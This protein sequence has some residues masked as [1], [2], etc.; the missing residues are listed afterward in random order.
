MQASGGP[1]SRLGIP[2]NPVAIEYNL[3][4]PGDILSRQNPHKSLEGPLIDQFGRVYKT[5]Y[6]E[7]RV[8]SIDRAHKVRIEWTIGNQKYLV[9]HT[10]SFFKVKK[11]KEQ[12]VSGPSR[13]GT[14]R[15]AGNDG[16]DDG[17]GLEGGDDDDSGDE[18]APE[19]SETRDGSVILCTLLSG[20]VLAFGGIALRNG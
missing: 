16:A 14:E 12:L 8:V 5:S 11:P 7:G 9:D 19:R 1:G 3:P 20:S 10:K 17:E 15:T 4:N 2:K 18:D 13:S 6:I